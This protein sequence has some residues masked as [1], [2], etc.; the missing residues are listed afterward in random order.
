MTDELVKSVSIDNLL[1][2]REAVRERLVAARAILEEADEIAEAAHLGGV[3]GMFNTGRYNEAPS[4]M[5][6]GVEAMMQWIDAAGWD[7]LMNE[8][9]MYSFFDSKS[10]EEWREGLQK[11]RCP[12]LTAES[13]AATFKGLF[14][15]RN[16]LFERGV[17][18]IFRALSW[19]YKTNKPFKFGKR[20]VMRYVCESWKTAKG[21]SYV[22]GVHH[23]AEQKM[24]DLAR[25]M[26]MLDGKPEADHRESVGRHFS[27]YVRQQRDNEGIHFPGTWECELFAL[28]Y[29]K[30]GNGH[31]TFKRMDV[32]D[33]M[34]KILAKHYPDAI[35]REHDS[36]V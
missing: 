26:S 2:Q 30:N 20:I 14:E 22:T 34:N 6:D 17:L 36:A 13:V 11:K 28:R 33:K 31:L 12:V 32:V 9:G 7:Y 18:E 35:A 8:S 15:Q 19:D 21:K 5:S 16:D 1:Q 10:R 3:A 23:A 29:F 4:I 25:V 27:Q 24:N